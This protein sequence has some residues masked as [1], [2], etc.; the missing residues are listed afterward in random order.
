MMKP[1]D[2]LREKLSINF[3]YQK[4]FE[5]PEGRRVLAHIMRVGGVTKSSFVAGDPHMT[6]LNEGKRWLALSIARTALS[7]HQ[8]L[9]KL[10][11]SG[12]ENEANKS[13]PEST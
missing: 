3:A 2:K 9:Q 7:D 12:V 6:S 1:F 11:E 5:T 10:I 8:E 4:V 13:N